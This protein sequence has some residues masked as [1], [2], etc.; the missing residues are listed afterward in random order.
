MCVFLSKVD[1][2]VLSPGRERCDPYQLRNVRTTQKRRW[3]LPALM[4]RVE[5]FSVLWGFA[6]G[7]TGGGEVLSRTA[8]RTPHPTHAGD[9]DDGSYTNSL[10]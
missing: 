8:A 1:V 9:Q 6:R 2:A 10:K 3:R 5:A 7:A 4:M